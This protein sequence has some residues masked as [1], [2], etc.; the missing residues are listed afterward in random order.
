MPIT[1]NLVTDF[2]KTHI[3]GKLL[4]DDVSIFHCFNYDVIMT[5]YSSFMN[6]LKE[7]SLYLPQLLNLDHSTVVKSAVIDKIKKKN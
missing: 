7:K 3:F 5:S 1:L 4:L 6:L 2:S